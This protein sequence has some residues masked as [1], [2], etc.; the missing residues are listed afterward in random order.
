MAHFRGLVEGSRSSETRLG[1]KRSGM[2]VEAQSWQGK[3][4]TYLYHNEDTGADMARVTL[5]NHMGHGPAYPV[6]VYEGPVSAAEAARKE[7]V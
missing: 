1:T 2:T 5:E 3:V 4:V 6:T 7:A